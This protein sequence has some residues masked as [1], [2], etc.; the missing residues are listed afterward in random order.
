MVV[1]IYCG[2]LHNCLGSGHLALAEM[3]QRFQHFFSFSKNCDGIYNGIS[4]QNQIVTEIHHNIL[5]QFTI[6]T[7]NCGRPLSQFVT[8]VAIPSQFSLSVT[9]FPTIITKLSPLLAKLWQT[10]PSQFSSQPSSQFQIGRHNVRYKMPVTKIPSQ[11]I[12]TE[13]FPSQLVRHN[14]EGPIT[15]RIVTNE[16]VTDCFLSQYEL[17]RHNLRNFPSQIVTFPVVNL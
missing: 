1:C 3:P 12:V 7:D 14:C 11:I 6:V 17:F 15:I 5:S 16:I 10:L 8:A 13:H 2:S 9:I 4:S